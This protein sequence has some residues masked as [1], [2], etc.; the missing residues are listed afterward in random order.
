MSTHSQHLSKDMRDLVKSYG[1]TKSKQE[2]DKIIATEL[3]SLK[4]NL[5]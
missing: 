2:E 1:E 3:V 4:N 5:S